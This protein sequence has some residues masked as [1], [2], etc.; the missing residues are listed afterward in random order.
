MRIQINSGEDKDQVPL[1]DSP[2]LQDFQRGWTSTSGPCWPAELPKWT[3]CPEAATESMVC[4][5]YYG[6]QISHRPAL[7]LVFCTIPTFEDFPF[8]Q[9]GGKGIAFQFLQVQL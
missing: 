4:R 1:P 8:G 3:T 2:T 6:A 5:T 7:A 9:F